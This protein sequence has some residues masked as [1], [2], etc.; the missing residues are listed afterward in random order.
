MCDYSLEAL[1]NRIAVVGETL[2]PNR[3]GDH[4]TV[5][6]V[7]PAQLGLPVCLCVGAKIRIERVSVQ[8]ENDYG[9]KDGALATFAQRDVLH[10]YRDGFQVEGATQEFILLQD[11]DDGFTVYVEEMPADVITH[12]GPAEQIAPI[13]RLLEPV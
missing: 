10:D 4:N 12:Q 8:L 5:A 1:K 7:S 2:I 6:L 9:I 13:G 3:L 11:L